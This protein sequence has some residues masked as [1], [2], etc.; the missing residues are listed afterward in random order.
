MARLQ[1]Q[2]EGQSLLCNLPSPET[3]RFSVGEQ[4][5]SEAINA[6]SFQGDLGPGAE[7]KS[8]V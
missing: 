2:M 6:V 4:A 7:D 1:G 8:Y 3:H 5:A